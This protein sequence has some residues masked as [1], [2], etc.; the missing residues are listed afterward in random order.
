MDTELSKAAG[1]YRLLFFQPNPEDGERVC[2]GVLL[3]EGR[4]CAVLYDKKFPKV[5][6]IAP[7]YEPELVKFYLDDLA[8]NLQPKN[9]DELT[10]TLR[11]YSPQLIA[12][13]ERSISLPV[14][15]Q[16]RMTLLKRF[17]L[18]ASKSKTLDVREA[19]FQA[20]SVD[21]F[22]D[23]LNRFVGN[24][25][26]PSGA[27]I[28][29]NVG[30]RE[31]FGRPMREMGAVAMAIRKPGRII[32]IDGVDLGIIT[33]TQAIDKANKVAHKFWKY[34]RLRQSGVSTTQTP[35]SRIGV[36][37]DGSIEKSA[38]YHE[39]HDYALHQFKKEADIAVDTASGQGTREF[40]EMLI[41][42]D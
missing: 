8:A 23:H 26:R 35:F 15:D 11:R 9:A 7:G 16:V 4:S 2:V 36:V 19:D 5:H 10:L 31:I 6:C 28:L 39:A 24:Y 27:E 13:E 12:S 30:S 37:L 17:V 34:G 32:M 14:T 21:L 42:M 20:Q 38:A 3:Q 41:S 22:A 25:I 40:E 1:K 33:S 18:P 29:R